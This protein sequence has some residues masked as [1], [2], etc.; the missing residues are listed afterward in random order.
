MTARSDR[1]MYMIVYI[2]L[3]R[4]DLIFALPYIS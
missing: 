2:I 4:F 3:F 1:N